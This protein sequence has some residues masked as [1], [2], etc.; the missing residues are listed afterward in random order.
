M[1]C[2]GV[3]NW[4]IFWLGSIF[5]I[6]HSLH[7]STHL[8]WA[9]I[10]RISDRPRYHP[11][12]FS[13]PW[14]LCLIYCRLFNCLLHTSL[15]PWH[16][17][18]SPLLQGLH[19]EVASLTIWASRPVWGLFNCFSL[20]LTAVGTWWIGRTTHLP[21]RKKDNLC[22]PWRVFTV[23]WEIQQYVTKSVQANTLMGI[24]SH[25]DFQAWVYIGEVSLTWIGEYI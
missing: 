5:E 24:G 7:S 25:V 12:V 4:I 13:V 15:L 21:T 6:L 18:M 20:S 17:L 2:G 9:C 23:K 14:V 8:Y 1:S 10:Y 16:F 11:F 3:V 22:I 19:T